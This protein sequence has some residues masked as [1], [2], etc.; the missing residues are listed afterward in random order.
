MDK[1]YKEGLEAGQEHL[2]P[3][4]VEESDGSLDE[5]LLASLSKKDFWDQVIICYGNSRNRH[6]VFTLVSIL[7]LFPQS[8]IRKGLLCSC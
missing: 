5:V 4:R 1:W 2:T 3:F 8:L 7:F 6:R